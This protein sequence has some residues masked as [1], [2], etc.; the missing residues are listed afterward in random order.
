METARYSD[1]LHSSAEQ[2]DIWRALL[3]RL[4]QI[5]SLLVWLCGVVCFF[6][7][8]HQKATVQTIEGINTTYEGISTTLLFTAFQCRE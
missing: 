4:Q 3:P 1:G 2:E 8:Q 5:F 6:N 7:S